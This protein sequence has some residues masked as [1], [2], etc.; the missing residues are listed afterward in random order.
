MAMSAQSVPSNATPV[1]PSSPSS[2][3]PTHPSPPVPSSPSSAHTDRDLAD[4]DLR[5]PHIK[6]ILKYRGS[7]WRLAPWI[8]RHFPSSATYTTYIEPFFGSGA[9]FFTKAPTRHEVLN[10]LSGDVVNLFRVLR[11]HGQALAALV[12]MTPWARAEYEASYTPICSGCEERLEAARRFLVRCWQAQ[13]L[14]F[15]RQTG[16]RHNGPTAHSPTTA[17]WAKLPARLLGAVERL[18]QAEIE[19]RSALDL[20]QRHSRTEVLLYADPPY[21]L[22]TRG[23]QRLYAHEMSDADHLAL[24]EAL[25]RHPGPVLLSGYPNP[26]YDDRLAHWQRFE[27]AAIAEGGGRRTEVLWVKPA[28]QSTL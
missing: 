23:R 18:K 28:I 13:H 1:A 24:L 22:A 26:L 27:A 8:V 9:V 6:A 19:C 7:K 2:L 25:E 12:A 11:E 10:D 14:D 17:L 5:A 21:V 16:W 15:T 3:L 4:G 20:I